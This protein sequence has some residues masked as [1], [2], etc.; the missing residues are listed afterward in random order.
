MRIKFLVQAPD[1]GVPPTARI[2]VYNLS[3]N[4]AHSI[5]K[6]YQG[7]VLQAG[8][9]DG[10]FGVIFQGSIVQVRVGR[11]NNISSFVEIRASTLDEWFKFGT[12][13]QS[14]A[15]GTNNKQKMDAIKKG[16][17]AQNVG[18]QIGTIPDSVGTGGV[19][20]RGKV[21]Y[22]F[23]KDY[24]NDIADSS[25]ASWSIVDGQAQFISLNSYA[26]GDIVKLNAMTGM[27]GVPEATIDGIEVSC[28]LNPQI[29]PGRRIQLNNKDLTTTS[30]NLITGPD[31]S[32][33]PVGFPNYT[34]VQYFA[35]LNADGIY[36]AIVVEHEGDS[37]A[38]SS[39]WYTH[40]TCLNLDPSSGTVDPYG[41][42]GVH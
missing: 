9:E 34:G 16:S 2:R 18:F 40:L 8:Y 21:F 6:E 31:G 38:P 3:R 27:V 15:A 41:D 32:Q 24:M 36:R 19:L 20:P 28:L 42:T 26:P 39:P 30:K 23:S 29:K 12:I 35:S 25:N 4:T 17:D 10:S 37:Y 1:V 22:G 14:V 33:L 5:Q 7:V 11:E 13:S